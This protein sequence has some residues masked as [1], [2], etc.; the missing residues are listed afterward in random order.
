MP[1]IVVQAAA[2]GLLDPIAESAC[3][4]FGIHRDTLRNPKRRT[5]NASRARERFIWLARTLLVYDGDPPKR[6]YAHRW[7]Q[8]TWEPISTPD[9]ARYLRCDHSSV[10]VAMGRLGITKAKEV[11]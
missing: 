5:R 8:P 6:R 4:S 2:D 1:G 10:V 9:I 7:E 3:E 11:A